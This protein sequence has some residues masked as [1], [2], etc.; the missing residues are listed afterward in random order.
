MSDN[1]S[2]ID[3]E[4]LKHVPPGSEELVQELFEC[5]KTRSKVSRSPEEYSF[6]ITQKTGDYWSAMLHYPRKKKVGLKILHWLRSVKVRDDLAVAYHRGKFKDLCDY[7]DE[8]EGV[9]TLQFLF[10]IASNG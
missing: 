8:W 3:L 9:Y 6:A 10:M 5:C 2:E 1:E 4:A 7:L